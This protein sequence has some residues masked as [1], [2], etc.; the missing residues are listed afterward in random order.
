ME[1]QGIHLKR[2][3]AF[4][5]I[6]LLAPS[7]CFAQSLELSPSGAVQID[8]IT[9]EGQR[10]RDE[11]ERSSRAGQSIQVEP[12][13]SSRFDTA[14]QLRRESSLTL[15]ETGRITPSG[16]VIPRIRGQDSKLTDIYLEDTILQDPYSGLPLVED[17]DL[18]AFGMFE[19]HQG[20]SPVSVANINPIG[21]MRFRFNQV[22]SSRASIGLST[23]SPYGLGIWSLGIQK[24]EDQEIRL[25]ARTHQTSG[26]YP[27][28][29]DKGTPYND[30]DDKRRI[31]S[32]ND[33]RSQQF[34]PTFRKTFGP[35]RLQALA[36]FHEAERGIASNSMVLSTSAR[37]ASK[38]Y[39]ADVSLG[40]EWKGLLF[41]DRMDLA[42]HLAKT[43]DRRE[44]SDPE[45]RVLNS[46]R[47]ATMQVQSDREGLRL[48]T[49][50]SWLQTNWSYELSQSEIDQSFEGIKG[51]SLKRDNAIALFGM[52]FN[53][54]DR[55]LFEYKH[56][57]QHQNDETDLNRHI[58]LEGEIDK[59]GT[60]KTSG[61]NALSVA[62][63]DLEDGIYLQW[64]KT[65]RLPALFEEFGNGSTVRPNARLKPEDIAH[66]EIGFFTSLFGLEWAFAQY[67]DETSNKIVFIPI[68]ANAS[69]ALNVSETKI[70]GRDASIAWRGESTNLSF[71]LSDI[72][73]YDTSRKEKKYLPAIPRQVYVTEWRQQ[74][75]SAWVSYLSSRYRSKVYRDLANAIELPG[76][77]I[78]DLNVDYKYRHFEI[79]LA[80]R[81]LANTTDVEISAGANKGRTAFSDFAGAPLPGRQ[82]VLSLVYNTEPSL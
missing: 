18:R 60:H 81:N 56:S 41:F 11:Q 30:A 14:T 48:R 13:E 10:I 35:Y 61:A 12:Q 36:W 73:A 23:G 66:K 54:F 7:S 28:Y 22:R 80:L 47:Q 39:L 79:G 71:K 68:L 70:R 62:Y 34:L 40:R 67:Q 75:A 69:K 2:I 82:W 74:W 32:N 65:Q 25:Y 49:E 50:N 4:F 9:V 26:R 5:L 59:P 45:K 15:P 38:G 58:F 6:L 53:P 46:S 21:T 76:A 20:V 3:P 63:G 77:I 31:R 42:F 52:A 8:V 24:S 33:Q 37:E 78:Y 43:D 27:Y 44:T 55:W 72:K 64:A 29:S 1:N 51:T 57:E 17:L 19:L 16:F